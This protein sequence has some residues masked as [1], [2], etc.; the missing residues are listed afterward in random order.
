M[1]ESQSFDFH[2][3]N[4]QAAPGTAIINLPRQALL[5]PD[6]YPVTEGALYSAGL[7]PWWTDEPLER[8]WEGLQH[9]A[10][11]PQVVAI[12][13]CGLDL[14]RG[15]S[16]DIQMRL[17]R[18][19]MNLAAACGKPVIL[20]CVRAWHLLLPLRREWPHELRMVV[21]GFRGKP[22]LARQLLTAGFELSFG[23]H[24]NAESYALTPPGLRHNE[25]DAP[26][27]ASDPAV[28]TDGKAPKN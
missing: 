15:G 3:H 16:I 9:W 19:Q 14:L 2:T 4:P 8:E 5:A 28:P 23:P 1:T 6:E 12:G 18:D 21:H 7:H 27:P 13:E 22:A 26:D 11:H 24:R 10:G 17:L 20:H 25:T